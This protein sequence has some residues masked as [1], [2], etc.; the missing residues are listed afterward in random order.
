MSSE[1]HSEVLL[2]VAL[3]KGDNVVSGLG[4][5]LDGEMTQ[6]SDT[7]FRFQNVSPRS[8]LFGKKHDIP[9]TATVLPGLTIRVSN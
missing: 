8:S 3:R 4:R 7:F 6:A 1:L 5:E 2:R 9:L